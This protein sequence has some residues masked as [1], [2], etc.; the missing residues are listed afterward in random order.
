MKDILKMLDKK[1]D[2]DMQ[3]LPKFNTLHTQEDLQKCISKL[4]TIVGNMNLHDDLSKI[5][6]AKSSVKI[7][8]RKTENAKKKKSYTKLKIHFRKS[9]RA[10]KIFC[11]SAKSANKSNSTTKADN[12][13]CLRCLKLAEL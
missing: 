8:A 11:N 5:K 4:T 2:E 12:V 9:S 3:S 7:T 13:T 6:L 1:I 10:K